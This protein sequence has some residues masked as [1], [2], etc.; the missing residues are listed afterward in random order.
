MKWK[1][2]KRLIVMQGPIRKSMIR[3]PV[4][5]MACLR[6]QRLP[7]DKRLLNKVGSKLLI[8]AYYTP[9]ILYVYS[10]VI[11]KGIK[12]YKKKLPILNYNQRKFLFL[13]KFNWKSIYIFFTSIINN[14]IFYIKHKYRNKRN[15]KNFIFTLF[16][17]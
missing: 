17:N 15:Y 11:Y 6:T 12:S 10:Y 16:D 4:G 8:M 14:H 13:Y 2:R 7:R 3:S 1:G 5:P 9:V